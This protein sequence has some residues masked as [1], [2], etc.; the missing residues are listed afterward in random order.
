MI[1]FKWVS[2]Y[3]LVLLVAAAFLEFSD[4]GITLVSNYPLIVVLWH[5]L[6]IWPIC[7]ILLT[8]T[9]LKKSYT[10]KPALKFL[11][12][13]IVLVLF[14]SPYFTYLKAVEA[15]SRADWL[16]ELES[17]VSDNPG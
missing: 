6:L 3:F 12:W 13:S 8:N 1:T 15:K 17:S 5:C 11:I 9:Y 2:I 7:L 4:A 10:E 16:I 14:V